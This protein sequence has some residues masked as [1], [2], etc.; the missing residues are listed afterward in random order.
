MIE[1]TNVFFCCKSTKILPERVPQLPTQPAPR[2]EG[3]DEEKKSRP[4][5][6]NSA[7]KIN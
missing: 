3:N 6:G 2:V 5:T 4:R 7:D 1:K